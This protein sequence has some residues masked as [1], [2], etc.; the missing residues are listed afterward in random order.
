MNKS[1]ISDD[2]IHQFKKDLEQHNDEVMHPIGLDKDDHLVELHENF[3]AQVTETEVPLWMVHVYGEQAYT[4]PKGHK[5]PIYTK[6]E[7]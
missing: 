3:I 6:K 1:E 5:S 7:A 4:E 2:E